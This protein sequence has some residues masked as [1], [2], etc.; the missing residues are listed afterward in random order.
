MGYFLYL[1]RQQVACNYGF[2][3]SKFHL[4]VSRI[5]PKTEPESY[6]TSYDYKCCQPLGA[7][8]YTNFGTCRDL[9]T[10][11]TDSPRE[12]NTNRLYIYL[13]RQNV[14]C[15]SNEALQMFQLD[16]DWINNKIRY[17]LTCYTS[18]NTFGTA[19]VVCVPGAPALAIFCFDA[20][21]S[22]L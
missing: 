3:L 20:T 16:T 4:N 2:M 6:N 12:K 15:N 1:D 22:I 5:L 11:S 8:L 17:R 14:T 13:D 10:T 7:P 19:C 9:Y 18:M 21:L